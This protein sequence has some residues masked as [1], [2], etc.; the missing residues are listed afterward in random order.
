MHEAALVADEAAILSQARR[1]IER[2][3]HDGA[4]QRLV[5]LGLELH[6]AVQATP[7]ELTDLRERLSRITADLVEVLDDLRRIARGGPPGALGQDGLAPA[8]GKLTGLS[9][10]PVE[11]DAGLECRLPQRVAVAVYYLVS[12][13]LTN[14]ARYSRA[15]V[16]RVRAEARRRSVVLTVSDDGIGGAD[17]AQGSGLRGLRERVEG[18]GG[19]LEVFSPPG[20]GTLLRARV[21][22]TV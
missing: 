2:D 21:P 11:L 22:F 16:V 12:E 3:L 13:A 5:F 4:Q 7:P 9:P 14:A 1:S 6:G 10:I 20:A 8:L 18:L 17:P 15:S 19:T